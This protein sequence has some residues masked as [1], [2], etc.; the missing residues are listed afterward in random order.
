MKNS[1][2]SPREQARLERR[3]QSLKAQLAQLGWISQG[4]LM[5]QPPNAWRWTR[6]VKAKTV[7]VALSPDQAALYKQAIVN[8]RTL[9][10]ILRQMRAISQKIL[11]GSV[12]G[13]QKRQ[14]RQSS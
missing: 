5:H 11:L 13:V 7:T 1:V 12:P 9:E 2:L 6:K 4:S 8:H 14:R 10:A 3:Y